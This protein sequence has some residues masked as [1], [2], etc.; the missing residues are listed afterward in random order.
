MRTRFFSLPSLAAFACLLLTAAA[1]SAEPRLLSARDTVRLNSVGAPTLSPDGTWVLYTQGE[2]DLGIDIDLD[3]DLERRTQL[4]RARPDGSERRQMTRGDSDISQPAWRPDGAQIS[5]LTRRAGGKDDGEGDPAPQQVY[6]MYADGGEAW[7]LTDH[8]EGISAYLWSPDGARLAF[9]AQDPLDDAKKRRQERQLDTV[10]VDTEFRWTHLWMWDVKKEKATR[11]TEGDFHITDLEWSPDSSRVAYV[12]HPTTKTDD[13]WNSDVWVVEVDSLE[14]RKVYDNPGS[15]VA[16]RFSPDGEWI[17]FATKPDLKTNT[18]FS[19]LRLEPADGVGKGRTLLEDF[20]R[21]FSAPIW[22]ADGR[23]IYWPAADRTTL[24]LFSVD[25]ESGEASRLPTP[26]GVNA[27]FDLARDGTRW[28]WSH[29]AP[30]HPAEI[31]SA[32]LDFRDITQVSDANPWLREEEVELATPRAVRWKNSEG[33]EIEGVLTVPPDYR[34]GERYP[35]I[36]HPHGGPSAVI[37]ESF[38]AGNQFLAA[39]GFVIL[40]P[41]FRGSDGYGQEFLNSNRQQWGLRDYDDCMT[42]VDYAIEQGWADPDRMVAYGWS[43]GGYMSFWISTQTDRFKVISPGAGLSNLYSMYSTTDVSNYLGWF[44]DEPWDNEEVYLRLSPIRHVKNVT[45]KVL[46]MTGAED[47]RVPPEQSV[48]FYRALRDLD[49]EAELVIFPREGHGIREPQ[50]QMDRLRRYLEAFSEAV[51]VEPRT[52]ARWNAAVAKA[53]EK[54]AEEKARLE[55]E[56]DQA[57][58][59][60]SAESARPSG[61]GTAGGEEAES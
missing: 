39:N 26:L 59:D 9:L 27:A 25:L 40:Q 11:L 33:Q 4:M 13:L 53:E 47:V 31:Y 58:G 10:V 37:Y 16:P 24:R 22:S 42:G 43:Y 34:E 5:F 61:E 60:R 8:P 54:A 56:K 30:S 6:L 17:A 51:D 45:T 41:N 18:Y 1:V 7:R 35:F 38:Q 14:T 20:D 49:K 50:H 28:V 44:F 55:K 52:E 57:E 36:L 46:I 3:E 29:T 15:D 2:R 12:S 21:E 48:E 19:A 32:A 23:T